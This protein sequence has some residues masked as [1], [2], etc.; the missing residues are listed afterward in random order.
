MWLYRLYYEGSWFDKEVGVVKP[1]GIMSPLVDGIFLGE[2]VRNKFVS[3]DLFCARMVVWDK[4]YL[5]CIID[6]FQQGFDISSKENFQKL[7]IILISFL[8]KKKCLEMLLY[9]ITI[10]ELII[11]FTF[12]L[13]QSIYKALAEFIFVLFYYKD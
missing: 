7:K 10:I 1:D 9:I 6:C 8:G 3:S 4:S 5:H 2:I 11:D 12:K 13:F